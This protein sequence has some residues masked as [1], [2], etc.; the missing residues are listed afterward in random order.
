[1]TLVREHFVTGTGQHLIGVH[2]HLECTGRACC[3]HQPSTHAMAALP[4]NWN[5]PMA[6]MERV[7]PCGAHH[8]DPDHLAHVER[9]AG[10]ELAALEAV[11][12]C[13]AKRCCEQTPLLGQ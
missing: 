13:C 1:M 11:H 5:D 3:V 7:C 8:P 6:R 10:A 9:A 2:N 12:E 4:T